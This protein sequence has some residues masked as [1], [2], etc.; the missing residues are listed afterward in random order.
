MKRIRI[1]RFLVTV[2]ILP[3]PDRPVHPA[4]ERETKIVAPKEVK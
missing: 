4:S 1:G 2:E 3:Q